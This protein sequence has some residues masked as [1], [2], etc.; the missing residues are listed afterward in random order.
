MLASSVSEEWG[1]WLI[2]VSMILAALWIVLLVKY[3]R[4][5]TREKLLAFEKARLE[6]AQLDQKSN[7]FHLQQE[8]MASRE[9]SARLEAQVQS[10]KERIEAT[11]DENGK[12][13]QI[14]S[15]Q[16][17]S[18]ATDALH[19][20]HNMLLQ[21]AESLLTR[22]RDEAASGRQLAKRDLDALIK[23]VKDALT[24]VDLQ[25]KTIEKQREGAY[26]GLK[27]QVETMMKL[28][29]EW[30]QEVTKLSTALK[31][32]V[33]KGKWGEIQLK[34]I[35][36]LAGME[37]YCDYS[38]QKAAG[39]T[40][41]L[42]PDMIIHL[43]GNRQIIID[44][45]TPLSHYF[46][47]MESES[48]REGEINLARLKSFAA[49]VRRHIT[50]LG[51]KAYWAQFDNS[52]EFVVLFLPG[53]HYYAAALRA[54]PSLLEVSADF[55][56]V[57]ATPSTLIGLLRAVS[58]GW[59]QEQ[60]ADNAKQISQLSTELYERV[61][62]FANHIGDMGRA[63]Q[64]A[65]TSYN[66]GV[67]SIDHRIMPTAKKLEKLGLK[68]DKTLKPLSVVETSIASL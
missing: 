45:K 49:A 6:Q 7:L 62:D 67:F 27:S 12:L 14:M 40:S 17:K 51:Q 13:S 28:Q 60:I 36:E 31:S 18:M 46:E 11:D 58:H 35:V 22:F 68:S 24:G 57:I 9:Q 16:F 55:K 2:V 44:A 52:P 38:E 50:S 8:L 63:L 42:R 5:F 34:R 39:P 59:R 43:P 3:L 56:V 41:S 66:K 20:S 33:V 53:D 54:D 47:A 29:G 15:E 26:H 61:L 65:V 32:P 64:H 4:L 30:A 1:P 48:L 23:P 25:I 37:S 10:L 21:S 19:C